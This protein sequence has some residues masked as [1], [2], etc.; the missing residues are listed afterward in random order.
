MHIICSYVSFICKETYTS[1]HLLTQHITLVFSCVQQ[2]G[3]YSGHY[4]DNTC[5]RTPIKITTAYYEICAL[6]TLFTALA[7]AINAK[8]LRMYRL[9]NTDMIVMF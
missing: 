2:Y 4:N 6:L 5:I 7:T 3:S 9:V 8:L 1:L